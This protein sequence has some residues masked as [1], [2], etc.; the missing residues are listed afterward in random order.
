MRLDFLYICPVAYKPH[1]NS[2]RYNHMMLLHVAIKI[3]VNRDMCQ[4]Y[5]TYAESLL[6]LYVSDSGKLY[7]AKFITF[8][9]HS[10]IHLANDVRKHG[11]L[12]EFSSFLFENKLQKMKNLQRRS[13][14][15]LQQIVR[16]LEEI[17]NANRLK[18]GMLVNNSSS[19]IAGQYKLEDIHYTGPILPQFVGAEQYKVLRFKNSV[20]SMSLGDNCVFLDNE[21]DV[22]II[23]NV[24]KHHERVHVI[25][26]R[27]MKKEDMYNYP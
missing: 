24:I 10:L 1:L 7:G 9:V 20:L 15:L 4:S 14:R 19:N 26:R 21:N 8:N 22:F 17:D 25:G 27:F 23:E 2:E 13:G 11:C 3:L 5:A 6:R 12:D 16:R 18:G